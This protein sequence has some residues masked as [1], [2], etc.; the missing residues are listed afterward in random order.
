MAC[1]AS[2][3]MHATEQRTT[4]AAREARRQR[5]RLP[6]GGPSYGN[7]VPRR[8]VEDLANSLM[9]SDNWLLPRELTEGSR[10]FETNRRCARLESEPRSP[11]LRS[12]FF[13]LCTFLSN[14]GVPMNRAMPSGPIHLETRK[15]R[16]S[17]QR[18]LPYAAVCDSLRAGYRGARLTGSIQ[19]PMA[20]SKGP[21]TI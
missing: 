2:R 17:S 14:E 4:H 19:K 1:H 20:L 3:R 12:H 15:G 18:C 16:R 10:A 13:T 5:A 7:S 8:R 6:H 9:N 21:G 11:G